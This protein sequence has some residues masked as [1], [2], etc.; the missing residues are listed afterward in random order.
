MYAY[1]QKKSWK[2]ITFVVIMQT[3]LM[4]ACQTIV[5]NK[6]RQQHELHN[7]FV[8]CVC[9]WSCVLIVFIYFTCTL[10]V[11][12]CELDHIIHVNETHFYRDIFIEWKRTESPNTS[13]Y[14]IHRPTDTRRRTRKSVDRRWKCKRMLNGVMRSGALKW[15]QP[16]T[17][18]KIIMGTFLFHWIL[19]FCFH[20]IH[21]YMLAFHE[22]HTSHILTESFIIILFCFSIF[23]VVVVVF[24]VTVAVAVFSLIF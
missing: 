15:K 12:W 14:D 8:L 20:R 11:V 3:H 10:C 23:S 22:T 4:Y 19:C 18:I 5:D 24:V 6:R 9:P 21:K 16:T 17:T 7:V 2:T 1:F 13:T